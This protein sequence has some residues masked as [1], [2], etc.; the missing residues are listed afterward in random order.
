VKGNCK[1]AFDAGEALGIP[2]VIEPADMDVLTV[3]DKL[4]V[5][6]YLYQLRA[7]F[8]GEMIR[9]KLLFVKC[10]LQNIFFKID[11]LCYIK[12]PENQMLIM[13]RTLYRAYIFDTI[14]VAKVWLLVSPC[15][16]VCLSVC[17]QQLE[18]FDLD[19]VLTTFTKTGYYIPVSFQI[20][21]QRGTSYVKTY[22]YFCLYIYRV[23][24]EFGG[25]LQERTE[26]SL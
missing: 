6:T 12:T 10:E 9:S 8:T 3:P 16:S 26:G 17:L 25:I 15:L 13:R 21:Q 18:L 11:S 14:N 7:H 1:K 2:R 23:S 4:A 20:G 24:Q 5:M 19:L 22:I